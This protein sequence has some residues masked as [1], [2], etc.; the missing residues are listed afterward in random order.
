MTEETEI[1]MTELL[2]Q[3]IKERR[4]LFGMTQ[5]QL[6]EL[7]FMEQQTISQYEH[8][9]RAIDFEKLDRIFTA[10]KLEMHILIK[11]AEGDGVMVATART[12]KKRDVLIQNM[13]DLSYAGLC[14]DGKF[15]FKMQFGGEFHE[16]AFIEKKENG[17]LLTIKEPL[18]RLEQQCQWVEEALYHLV[19]YAKK[20]TREEQVK[21]MNYFGEKP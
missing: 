12:G 13:N 1:T 14:K 21:I 10:L 2:A 19:G 16:V 9:K 6:A 15:R 17:F 7:L 18:L 11:D 3:V 4:E 20:L 8:T 5:K